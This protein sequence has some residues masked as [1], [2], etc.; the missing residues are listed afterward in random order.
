MR[1]IPKR[2]EC[3]KG[4]VIHMA[5]RSFLQDLQNAEKVL[6]G[7]GEEFDDLNMLRQ[8][9]CYDEGREALE[10][11][12][13]EWLIPAWNTIAAERVSE[14]S[15]NHISAAIYSLAK[16]LADKDYF[17]VSASVNNAIREAPWKEGRLVMPCGGSFL[18]QCK[19][20]CG[21]GL[22]EVTEKDWKW[23]EKCMENFLSASGQHTSNTDSG[24]G[25]CQ[26]CGSPLILNNIYAEK[27]DENGYLS[28]WEIY[29]RW[30]QGTLN[31]KLLVLELG[32]GMQCP[33]VIRWPF[34]KIAFYN[35]RAV[36]YRV[37]KSL[38]Q[39]TEELRDKGV[40]IS[41]NAADWLQ[42]L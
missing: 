11:S 33:T 32:V 41:Q 28:Q 14:E 16:L 9:P 26:K 42:E 15:G 5:Q 12:G 6:I 22:T 31:K 40:G 29:T 36:F 19:N 4:M 39:L 3:K 2:A 18:K 1:V 35:Q 21:H 27:Y 8:I 30:L 7:I 24:L 25:V 37:N 20:G 13:L 17:V 10:I 23:M 38:Y 34:E